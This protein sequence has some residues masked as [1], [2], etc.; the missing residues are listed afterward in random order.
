MFLLF[1]TLAY[2]K[3]LSCRAIIFFIFFWTQL[4]FFLL[5][6]ILG[7]VVL[8]RKQGL[9]IIFGLLSFVGF[10]SIKCVD[11]T[12]QCWL[13][14]KLMHLL[15]HQKDFA[16]FFMWNKEQ[17][18]HSGAGWPTHTA[19][20]SNHVLKSYGVNAAFV[21]TTNWLIL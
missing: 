14:S 9:M 19:P 18:I 15:F 11:C 2:L 17:P 1:R 20:I 10:I 7:S 8:P 13:K 16:V 3:T 4:I 12:R 5:A 21:G 6:S